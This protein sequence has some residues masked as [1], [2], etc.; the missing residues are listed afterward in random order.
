[1]ALSKCQVYTLLFFTKNMLT[2]TSVDTV[3]LGHVA[4][5]GSKIL[6]SVHEETNVYYYSSCKQTLERIE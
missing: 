2:T 1:M 4:I 3:D 5:T 6:K